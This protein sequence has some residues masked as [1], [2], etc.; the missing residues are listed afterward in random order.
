MRFAILFFLLLLA[1]CA[2]DNSFVEGR[3]A[4]LR[5][6]FP[7]GQATRDGVHARL[8]EPMISV[9]R[10]DIGWKNEGIGALAIRTEERTGAL[11]G[12]VEKHV[13]PDVTNAYGLTLAHVWYF[14]DR[15]D[16]V[17]DVVWERWGD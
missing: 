11:V 6:A 14:Y 12:R 2:H 5:E 15:F 1:A 9:V 17:A 4:R 10:P 8:G 7:T 16:V 13:L 3:T